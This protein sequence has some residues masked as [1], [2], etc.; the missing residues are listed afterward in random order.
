MG[1]LDFFYPVYPT[2][3][4]WILAM[5]ALMVVTESSN[6]RAWWARQMS[7][8]YKNFMH[9]VAGRSLMYELK[10][11]GASTYRSL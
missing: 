3:R 8:A 1:A 2:R 7:S 6:V 4:H 10:R 11:V 5:S 9:V